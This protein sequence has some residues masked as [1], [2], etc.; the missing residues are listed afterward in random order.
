V[1]AEQLD[2]NG[3]LFQPSLLQGIGTFFPHPRIS[4][5]VL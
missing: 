5:K 2:R 3:G 4:W 1:R